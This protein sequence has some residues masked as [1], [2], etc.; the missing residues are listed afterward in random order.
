MAER[1]WVRVVAEARCDECGLVA[2][3]VPRDAIAGALRDEATSWATLFGRV[4]D[5]DA[6]RRTGDGTWST[7]EYAAHVRDV[8]DLFVRRVQVALSEHEPE[9]GWWDH[10][11]AVTDVYYNAQA[12]KTVVLALALYAETLATVLDGLDEAQWQRRGTRRGGEVFTVEGLARFGL[13]ETR[14]HRVDAQR[15]LGV[16]PP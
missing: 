2:S 13:H 3:A 1:D 4:Q 8:L 6:R 11:A 14:H 9:F 5:D 12:P 15:L 7:L 10:E 16:T